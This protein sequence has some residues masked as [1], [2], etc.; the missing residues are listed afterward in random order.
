MDPTFL[1]IGIGNTL[2]RDDGA[3]WFFA[4]MLADALRHA[5]AAVGLILQQQ[6]T[7]ETAEIIA[8]HGTVQV[9]FVDASVEAKTVTIEA[10]RDERASSPS[11]HHVAPATLLAVARRL[12]G[13][14]AAGWL[15]Q[16]PARDLSHGEGLSD[17]AASSLDHA[18]AVAADLL[19]QT[20]RR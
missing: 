1:V 2:R 19:A 20:M 17:H 14:E 5:G 4:Q 10:V 6:L 11:S 9:I 16:F 7:P 13:A 18:G 3:G 15:V 8:E 12:Y